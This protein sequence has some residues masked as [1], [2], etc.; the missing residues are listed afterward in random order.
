MA[1]TFADDQNATFSKTFTD[2][3]DFTI[4]AHLKPT[5]ASIDDWAGI[6]V[7][8]PAGS[9][10]GIILTDNTT[11]QHYVQMMWE[12]DEWSNSSGLS[13]SD[14][15]WN[16]V[17]GTVDSIDNDSYQGLSGGTTLNSYNIS[18]TFT[19]KTPAL[20]AIGKDYGYSSR[21]YVGDMAEL[22]IW[23]AKLTVAELGSLQLG[24][25]PLFIRPSSLAFYCP[26]ISQPTGQTTF[27]DIVG[28]IQVSSASL[29]G[30]SAA[31]PRII[32]PSRRK[33]FVPAAAAAS[34]VF[35][36]FGS[37]IIAGVAQ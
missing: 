36:I 5:D 10:N 12:G 14:G 37:G 27:Q 35:D 2:A 26:M 18:G 6:C 21:D 19:A 17:A 25:S 30:D 1:L 7:S 13:L 8:R 32:N 23:T 24:Y 3:L 20:W 34:G 29:E 11:G 4:C 33:I 28:G 31:H 9:Q 16:F 22:A 15:A